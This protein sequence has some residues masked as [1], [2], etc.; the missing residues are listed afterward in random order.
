MRTPFKFLFFIYLLLSSFKIYADLSYYKA[1][2]IKFLG[3]LFRN[4]IEGV[5]ASTL[6]PETIR[7]LVSDFYGIGSCYSSVLMTP[8]ARRALEKRG[9]YPA[10]SVTRREELGGGASGAVPAAAATDDVTH[11]AFSH[12]D[13][14]LS[15]I[16][17]EHVVP[18]SCLLWGLIQREVDLH[19]ASY[20]G[21]V[22]KQATFVRKELLTLLNKAL[23]RSALDA[24]DADGFLKDLTCAERAKT[25]APGEGVVIEG[26]VIGGAFSRFHKEIENAERALSRSR[27]ATAVPSVA[28]IIEI[29]R[30]FERRLFSIIA[31]YIPLYFSPFNLRLSHSVHNARRGDLEPVLDYSFEEGSS[32]EGYIRLPGK[33][34][35]GKAA[36]LFMLPEARRGEFARVYLHFHAHGVIAL[37]TKELTTYTKWS[38]RYPIT[39]AEHIRTEIFVP[40]LTRNLH[41]IPEINPKFARISQSAF[42]AHLNE[43]SSLPPSES[44]EAFA[45]EEEL[46]ALVL[47]M[48][49]DEARAVPVGEVPFA[50][51]SLLEAASVATVA[52]AATTAATEADEGALT[53]QPSLDLFIDTGYPAPAPAPAP[54]PSSVSPFSSASSASFVRT[55][56]GRVVVTPLGDAERLG[57]LSPQAVRSGLLSSDVLGLAA[58]PIREEEEE[59]GAEDEVELNLSSQAQPGR[60]PL[61][62]LRT[63]LPSAATAVATPDG[64][65][66]S[67]IS[68]L[69]SI[70][71]GSDFSAAGVFGLDDSRDFEDPSEARVAGK[72][73]DLLSP[74]VR[75]R[76]LFGE[77]SPALEGS[78]SQARRSPALEGSPSQARTSP[79]LE[80]SPSQA[81]TSPAL[82]RSSVGVA[83]RFVLEG[84]PAR[85]GRSPV[86]V[87]RSPVLDGGS[88]GAGRSPARVGRSPV[89]DGG[90]SGAG[91]ALPVDG[92]SPMAQILT[93]ILTP[94]SSSSSFVE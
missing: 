50:M 62:P 65:D 23:T 34:G 15:D 94:P 76:F 1:A 57:L 74:I 20:P 71:R 29:C 18:A 56:G 90:S 53:A 5:D 46:L 85:V 68:G 47:A 72:S 4:R 58:F 75:S 63:A 27:S 77:R 24:G 30:Q 59:E 49:A 88:S 93:R 19:F 32:R 35:K 64:L 2:Y 87:G 60:T 16:S 8:D 36:P 86:R 91:R 70:S 44:D 11:Y 66:R 82:G 21:L 42:V 38:R 45:S 10:P 81:R 37:D 14:S 48:T 25:A 67:H 3:D 92:L 6:D 13:A 9:L 73:I 12:I 84:S 61:K 7:L 80:G 33:K 54:A 22:G 89:L 17:V 55:P 79:A 83:R 69:S 78:P 51:D 26:V 31:Q 43:K 28:E 40:W 41:S 52:T 39:Q